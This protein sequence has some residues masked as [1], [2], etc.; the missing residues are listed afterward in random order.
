MDTYSAKE[1]CEKVG[2]SA[3]QLEYWSLIGVVK[4]ILEPHGAKMFKRY[5]ECDLRVLIEVKSLTDEGVLVS[6]AAQR[7]KLKI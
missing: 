6:R 3:R 1:I 2:I 4:P 5:T 7:V